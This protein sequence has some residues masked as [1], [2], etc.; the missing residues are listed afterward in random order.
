MRDRD[1]D[2]EEAQRLRGE[3]DRLDRRA[4]ELHDENPSFADHLERRAN[5]CRRLARDADSE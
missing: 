1:A 4:A 2:R 3:A 5:H